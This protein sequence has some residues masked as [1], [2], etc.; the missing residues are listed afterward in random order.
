MSTLG[1][2]AKVR[3]IAVTKLGR[4][5]SQAAGQLETATGTL[6]EALADPLIDAPEVAERKERA[7]RL[8]L[9]AGALVTPEQAKAR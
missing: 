2:D 6:R 3:Y 4:D 8:L 5:L 1:P 7:L 9:E